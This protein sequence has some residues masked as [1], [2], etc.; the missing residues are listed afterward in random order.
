MALRIFISYSTKD[1]AYAAPV[2]R[3]LQAAGHVAYFAEET[4]KAGAKLSIELQNEIQA[5]D[6]FVVLW[7]RNAKDS[8]W[9]S[10][11]IGIAQANG[12]EIL[13]VI[14]EKGLS[15]PGFISDRKYLPAHQGFEK[16]IEHLENVVNHHATEKKKKEEIEQQKNKNLVMLGLGALILLAIN[17]D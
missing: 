9:V 6:V 7:S 14:L 16:A 2:W 12:K 5:C 10:Q 4:A 13:P 1:I 11:E 17:S 15:A 8:D 3:R